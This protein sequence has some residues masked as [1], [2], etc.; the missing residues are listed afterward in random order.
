M[1]HI[2]RI[3]CI[4]AFILPAK[5]ASPSYENFWPHDFITNGAPPGRIMLN[6]G[7]HLTNG[8]PDQ[9][10]GSNVLEEIINDIGGTN[11]WHLVGNDLSPTVGTSVSTTNLFAYT[12]LNAA[13]ALVLTGTLTTN[14]V[15]GTNDVSSLGYDVIRV[16]GF[17]ASTNGS[18]LRLYAPGNG[19]GTILVVQN[20]S[21]GSGFT[22]FNNSE[23]AG[24][25][26]TMIMRLNGDWTP[27]RQGESIMLYNYGQ[28]WAEI[29][30]TPTQSITYST[31]I[32]TNVFT[33]SFTLGGIT[34]VTNDLWHVVA[35]N[36]VNV[37]PTG[38][39]IYNSTNLYGG[40]GFIAEFQS[41]GTNLF[42]ISPQLNETMATIQNNE[43]TAFI[44]GSTLQFDVS[45]TLNGVH[46]AGAFRISKN[47]AW[48][49]GDNSSM[50]ALATL[51]VVDNNQ[52]WTIWETTRGNFTY[53]AGSVIGSAD[54]MG[55]STPLSGIGDGISSR[56]I[57]Q[58]SAGNPHNSSALM[59]QGDAWNA[60]GGP[61]QAQSVQAGFWVQA[62][63]TA[64]VPT[65]NVVLSG[66][67]NLSTPNILL[68]VKSDSGYTG[69]GANFLS[70]D[71]TY[72]TAGGGGVANTVI[73]PGTA[74][75]SGAVAIWN[76]T[77]GTNITQASG[78]TTSGGTNLTVTGNLGFSGTGSLFNNPVLTTTQKNALSPQGGSQVYD[79]DL[80]RAQV[81][82]GSAWHSRVRLDG[83]TMSGSLTIQQGAA[84][85]LTVTNSA[86][87]IGVQINGFSGQTNDLQR[88]NA[89]GTNE[90]Y[91]SNIGAF[92]GPLGTTANPT[93]S[94]ATATNAG[95]ALSTSLGLNMIFK[96]TAQAN[97]RDQGILTRQNYAY[98]FTGSGGDPSV[99]GFD[100]ALQ[101]AS[102]LNLFI[103]NGSTVSGTPP[104]ASLGAQP[105]KIAGAGSTNTVGG[106]FLVRGGQSTG[107]GAG[108]A[109]V[110]QVSPAGVASTNTLNAFVDQ[111]TVNETT[112]TVRGNLIANNTVA[113]VEGKMSSTD[114]VDLNTATKTTLFTVPAGK[115]LVVTKI[116]VRNASASLTTASFSFGYNAN[117]DDVVA[118]ATHTE[119]TGN[120]LY[121]KIEPKAGAII[122]NAADV[123]GVKCTILQGSAATVTI[124]VFGYF[125]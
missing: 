114:S 14:M 16:T 122:G 35:G 75:T 90:S 94:F 101:C 123:F 81:Y 112:T 91:I 83:D 49:S 13:G 82:D 22:M 44:G 65:Y 47:G 64:G 31:A 28:G 92:R 18:F 108:G 21:A 67:T 72:K 87:Q 50:D 109:V 80:G 56:S 54:P 68:K 88:W 8:V 52:N 43:S 34:I 12:T 3:I 84:T 37:G 115:T 19:L 29:G 32:F 102:S 5:A 110:L 85:G 100:S 93:Y 11:Y 46:Q 48:T 57:G 27:N 66:S 41:S 107:T 86:E 23:C 89:G 10:G 71:G 125:F 30:R 1:K 45:D 78:I 55:V 99:G 51:T 117:A 120:T 76:G 59:M 97:I 124:S 58:A 74:V 95:L 77:T 63:E 98:G 70:D 6:L 4:L 113:I 36:L 33:T 9:P 106:R 17:N 39:L 69:T 42:T 25:D 53:L 96:G 103:G 24:G 7:R 62:V 116:I 121:T 104:D 61:A 73:S 38:S 119:L 2:F 60:A 105:C 79:S 26:P 15:A 118:T 111:V 40:G 20:Y